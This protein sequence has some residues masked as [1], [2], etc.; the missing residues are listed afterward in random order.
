ML[1]SSQ[2]AEMDAIAETAEDGRLHAKAIVEFARDPATAL[3]KAFTW[4]DQEAAERYR[5]EQAR[6]LVEVYIIETAENGP[7][8][9]FVSLKT[10]RVAG[11][12]YTP[13]S[14]A[15]ASMVTRRALVAQ[16]IE[17]LQSTLRRHNHVRKLVTG[18]FESV[19][20]AC[21]EAAPEQPT[22]SQAVATG[23]ARSA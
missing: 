21:S 2:R 7:V 19:E 10:D 9:A 18:L 8:R 14:E 16:C 4:D 22:A 17:D 6:G 12:G 15:M 13:M 20:A 23:S 3:H 5:L 11:G 1:T